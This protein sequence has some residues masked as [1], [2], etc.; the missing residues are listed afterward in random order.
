MLRTGHRSS[1][2]AQIGALAGLVVVAGVLTV[3]VGQGMDI[4][5]R[6]TAF[7]R[8]VLGSVA[9]DSGVRRLLAAIN[10]PT[11]QLEV[12]VGVAGDPYPLELAGLRLS[13]AIEGEAGKI[14]PMTILPL[15]LEQYVAEVDIFSAA[16]RAALLTLLNKAREAGDAAAA[17]DALHAYLLAAL[18]TEE[19]ARDFSVLSKLAGVDPQLA[20]ERVLRALPDVSDTLA[21][22]IVRDRADGRGITARSAYF[23]TGR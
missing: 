6:A 13:L 5:R 2:F 21:A 11:D 12:S 9:G 7:D 23:A 15:V 17:I 20:S 4:A 8:V 3:V 10:D 1:G 18:T 22:E 19:I 16:D 14:N